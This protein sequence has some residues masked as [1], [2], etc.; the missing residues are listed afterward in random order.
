[1]SNSR[2]Q[3][4][5]VRDALDEHRQEVHDA[6]AKSQVDQW[7]HSEVDRYL[8]ALSRSTA[9]EERK[10]EAARTKAGVSGPQELL[11]VR[12][13]AALLKVH[14]ITVRKYV[15]LGVLQGRKVIGRILIPKSSVMKLIDTA[16]TDLKRE[17]K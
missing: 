4:R 11:T 10:T 1:M 12:E 7:I 13:V 17:E 2:R 15:R 14:P 16:P 9:A 5:L 6:L 8:T 3:D